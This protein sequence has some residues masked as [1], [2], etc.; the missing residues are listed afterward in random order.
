MRRPKSMKRPRSASTATCQPN[1]TNRSQAI[2]LLR[3]DIAVNIESPIIKSRGPSESS[4]TVSGRLWLGAE[5]SLD[6]SAAVVD[7]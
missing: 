4:P 1:G 6:E 7:T 3:R 2:L 5:V